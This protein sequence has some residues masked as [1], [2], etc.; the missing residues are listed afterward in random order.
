LSVRENERSKSTVTSDSGVLK[1][2]L[3]AG[4]VQIEVTGWEY[5]I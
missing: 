2:Q 1:Q 3:K 4:D 5:R